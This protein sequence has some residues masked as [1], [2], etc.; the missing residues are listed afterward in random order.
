LRL[1]VIRFLYASAHTVSGIYVSLN[2]GE[3][4]KNMK[5]IITTFLM[6]ST[7]ALV[8]VMTERATAAPAP[9]DPARAES[10]AFKPCPAGTY[11]VRRNTRTKKK[12]VNA[13]IAGG[14]GAA[15]GGGI[16]GGRGALIGL[17]SGSGG[18]LVYRYVRDRRGRCVPRYVRG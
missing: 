9:M 3:V 8:P 11:R 18:Y 2:A 14:V 13:L 10:V 7:F 17:G 4:F 5:K 16:G 15:I 1:G 6:V 12:L